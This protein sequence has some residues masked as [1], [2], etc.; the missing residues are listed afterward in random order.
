MEQTQPI[1]G[2]F[3]IEILGA[4]AEFITQKLEEHVQKLKDAGVQI[5]TEKYEEPAPKDNL[6][7]QFVELQIKFPKMV[8]LL[9]FC[10]DSMPSS[11]EIISPEQLT[12]DTKDFEDLLND[13]QAKLHH[14]DMMLKGLQAQKALLDKNAVNVFHNF[15]KFACKAPQ[16]LKELTSL[17]GM[18]EK[19]LTPFVDG[20]VQKGTL[21]KDG[22][23]YHTNG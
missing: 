1:V 18:G 21:K 6:F 10:F 3:I 15:I 2:R 11:V 12:L 20:L 19:E 17:L 8:D 9:D 14:A 13:F 4:P 16:T 7:T 5:I 22:N 23:K